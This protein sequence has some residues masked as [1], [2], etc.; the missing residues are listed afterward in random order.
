MNPTH[1]VA[2]AALVRNLE[3]LFTLDALTQLFPDDVL[4]PPAVTARPPKDAAT[5]AVFI[6][7][8]TGRPSGSMSTDGSLLVNYVVDVIV[9]ATHS[10]PD[11]AAL[12]VDRYIDVVF[13]A[14]IC[15]PKLGGTV[16]RPTDP[17]VAER[18]SYESDRRRLEAARIEIQIGVWVESANDARAI[19][20]A[21][22]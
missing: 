3:A 8:V 7:D 21:Q 20:D 1:G 22:R 14:A 4:T 12:H 10:S 19:L 2:E 15:D 9:Q 5:H 16:T 18:A 17:V 11:I 6:G 13:Q